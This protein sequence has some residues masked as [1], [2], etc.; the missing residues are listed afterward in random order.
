MFAKNMGQTDRL[1]R[2]IFGVVAIIL[3]FTLAGGLKWLALVVG[4]VMLATS[5]MGSCPPYQIL[6]INTCKTKG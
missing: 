3:F 6:G 2:A 1:I 4:I 5:A